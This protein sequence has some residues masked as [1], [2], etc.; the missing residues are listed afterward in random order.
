MI[1]CFKV[2]AKPC[3]LAVRTAEPRRVKTA[4]N[5]QHSKA[6]NTVLLTWSP[7][8][9]AAKSFRVLEA[10]NLVTA[11]VMHVRKDIIDECRGSFSLLL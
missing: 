3:S 5:S 9:T 7:A 11:A 1:A 10:C 8:V 6:S 4:Q 2:T